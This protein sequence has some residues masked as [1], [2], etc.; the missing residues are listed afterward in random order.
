MRD[1]QGLKG[2]TYSTRNVSTR[3]SFDYWTDLVCDEFIQLDCSRGKTGEKFK[4]KIQ[5]CR[6]GDLQ[7]SLVDSDPQHVARSKR[8]ISRATE[9]EFLLSLQLEGSGVVSQDGR[10]ADLM[11]GDFA[12]YDSTR[13]YR[14]HFVNPFR[15][16]VLQFPYTL[17]ARFFLHPEKITAR[18]ISAQTGIGGLTS[19]FIRSAASQLESLS[20][21]DREMLAEH[22]VELVAVS[23]GSASSLRKLDGQSISRTRLLNCIKQYIA[24]NISDPQLSP[25]LVAR[26]HRISERYQRMLFSSSGTTIS[27][28]ILERRLK[29]CKESLESDKLRHYNISQLAFHYGFNDAAYFS[30]QF[31]KR[32]GVSPK[33]YRSSA[34]LSGKER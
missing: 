7:V 31:K 21:Q 6:M 2:Y 1:F 34:R 13:L 9:S 8:H 15:Q 12:L 25:S 27:R 20:I 16:L 18:P 29:L 17:L 3:E 30:R 5:G 33:K 4:G 24:I 14:L 19:K 28:Y 32:Y 10:S 22:I 23:M 11:L 26:H